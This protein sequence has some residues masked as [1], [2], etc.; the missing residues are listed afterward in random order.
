MFRREDG[1][2]WEGFLDIGSCITVEV[3]LHSLAEERKIRRI[4]RGLYDKLRVNPAPGGKL[5]SDIDEAARA[6]ARRRRWKIVPEGFVGRE[7]VPNGSVLYDFGAKEKRSPGGDQ[8]PVFAAM[9][10]MG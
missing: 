3:A 5:G 4:Q 6:I 8:G 2:L 9:L 7:W 10:A 1:L